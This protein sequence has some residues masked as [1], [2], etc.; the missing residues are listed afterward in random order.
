MSVRKLF[1]C[2]VAVDPGV[3]AGDN[4][5]QGGWPWVGLG[6]GFIPHTTTELFIWDSCTLHWEGRREP[7]DEWVS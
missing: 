5:D 3:E 2:G 4:L 6:F 1:D 7:L